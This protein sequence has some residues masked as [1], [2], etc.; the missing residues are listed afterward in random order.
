MVK[1]AIPHMISAIMFSSFFC[2]FGFAAGCFLGFGLA[3]IISFSGILS[4][5]QSFYGLLTF[6]S[7]GS[8]SLFP[9]G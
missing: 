7:S 4:K 5:L 1:N 2:F 6:C 9:I 8:V 3:F